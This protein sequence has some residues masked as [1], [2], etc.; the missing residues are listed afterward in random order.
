MNDIPHAV[1]TGRRVAMV[2]LI[3]AMVLTLVAVITLIALLATQPV[4][5]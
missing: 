5:V 1:I 4:V 3:I 2:G